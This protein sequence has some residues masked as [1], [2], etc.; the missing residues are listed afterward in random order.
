MNFS[1]AEFDQ[2]FKKLSFFVVLSYNLAKFICAF[3][4]LTVLVAKLS[5]VRAKFIL[6]IA[7]SNTIFV[8]LSFLIGAFFKYHVKQF[9]FLQFV[10]RLCC[11]DLKRDIPVQTLVSL[12]I[13][14]SC[15][16]ALFDCSSVAQ[17]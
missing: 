11:I 5:F 16:A 15:K 2:S 14:T 7:K 13:M 8:K 6:V 9:R 1:S 12:I 3:T 4:K 10:F 17:N